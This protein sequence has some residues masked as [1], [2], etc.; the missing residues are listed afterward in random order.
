MSTPLIET[1]RLLLRPT[2]ISDLDRWAEM[3]AD[4]ECARFLGGVQ[5]RSTVWR[6][7]MCMAGCWQLTGIS[8]FSVIE[9]S[10]GRWLGRIGPWYPDGWPGREVGWGLHRD[11]WGQGIALE[12]SRAAMDYAFDVLGWDEVIHSIAPGNLP[13]QNLAK[14]LGSELRGPGQL[15]VRNWSS[16]A[17]LP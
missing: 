17:S 5:A 8:M 12:A 13:S 10:S 14:R 2:Q 16:R 1:E 11:A 4:E 15:P 3:M 6:A 9:R 7:L